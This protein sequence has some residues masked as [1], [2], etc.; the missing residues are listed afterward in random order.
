MPRLRRAPGSM[1]LRDL[2]DLLVRPVAWLFRE[3]WCWPHK[4]SM[5]HDSIADPSVAYL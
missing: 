1:S 5:T 2:S 3:S 4:G